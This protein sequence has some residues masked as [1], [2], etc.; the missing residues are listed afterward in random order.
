MLGGEKY[1][2]EDFEYL[3]E[4]ETD[5]GNFVKCS[6]KIVALLPGER[7]ENAYVTKRTKLL[8][9]CYKTPIN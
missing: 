6:S 1:Q 8:I 5:D 9:Y 2:M 4:I 7:I 3:L